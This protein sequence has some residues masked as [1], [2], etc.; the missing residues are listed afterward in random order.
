MQVSIEDFKELV[1]VE[2]TRQQKLKGLSKIKKTQVDEIYRRRNN[3]LRRLSNEKK[4]KQ[5]D[6]EQCIVDE[7]V[8]RYP[9]EVVRDALVQ[10]NSIPCSERLTLV[11]FESIMIK[12]HEK[13]MKSNHQVYYDHF[14]NRVIKTDDGYKEFKHSDNKFY[15]NSDTKGKWVEISRKELKQ[16]YYEYCRG[17]GELRDLLSSSFLEDM[18]IFFELDKRNKLEI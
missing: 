13:P 17:N 15:T 8:E 12:R 6:P 4:R 18:I 2:R 3:Y 10:I 16:Y 11:G 14:C 5:P 1:E 7:I 9:Y